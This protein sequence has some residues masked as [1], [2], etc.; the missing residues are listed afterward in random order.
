MGVSKIIMN[1]VTW[2]KL[3]A[4]VFD[5]CFIGCKLSAK[6][7]V[8]TI[9]ICL[10]ILWQAQTAPFASVWP[11]VCWTNKK[12]LLWKHAVWV[13]SEHVVKSDYCSH[14]RLI[15]PMGR[16][17]CTL[18]NPPLLFHANTLP[19]SLLGGIVLLTNHW[20][21]YFQDGVDT[22]QPQ[23]GQVIETVSLFCWFALPRV[24]NNIQA[25]NLL[26]LSGA[27]RQ[28]VR[29]DWYICRWYTYKETQKEMFI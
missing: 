7:Q 10:C 28:N 3:K 17:A 13:W 25:K 11:L 20:Y 5:T 14:W 1:S 2:Q 9:N 4:D 23:N 21:A 19:C 24:F 8:S 26:V 6:D 12:P 27:T 29:W 18:T 15:I 22:T 16:A